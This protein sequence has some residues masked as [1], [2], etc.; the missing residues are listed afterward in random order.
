MAK[1]WLGEFWAFTS[2]W[3]ECS[4]AVVVSNCWTVGHQAPLSMEFSRQE[5]WSG[6][7]FPSPRDLPDPGIEPGSPAF[8][9]DSLPTELW[10]KILPFG[11][12]SYEALIQLSADGWQLHSLPVSCLAWGDPALRSIG[13]ESESVTPS[14]FAKLFKSWAAA[15]L[16]CPCYFPGKHTGM[17]VHFLLQGIC[18]NP[19]ICNR[20]YGR[21]NGNLQEDLMPRDIFQGCCCQCPRPCGEPLLIHTFTGDPPTLAGR[22]GSVSWGSWKGKLLLSPGSWCTQ[23]DS[24]GKESCNVGDAGSI[25]GWGRSPCG[26]NGS[27]LQYWKIPWTKEPD[28]L[29][30]ICGVTKSRTQVG[31]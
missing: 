27:S 9:A 3:D 25:P 10:G 24:V 5:Y 13:P 1:A 31:N 8:Q 15:R 6:L 30:S 7:P 21:A 26:G 4:C 11:K 14:I 16:L 12:I 18:I 19:I 28:E 29:Q 17:G 23:D 2:V 22:S 20:L